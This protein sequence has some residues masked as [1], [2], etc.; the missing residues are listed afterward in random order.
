[1]TSSLILAVQTTSTWSVSAGLV[2]LLCNLFAI[3]VGRFAIQNPGVGPDLP[4]PKPALWKNF[5]VPE[6]I[7][8]A[9]LGHILGAGMILGLSNA[10]AL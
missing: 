5:G 8:T 7:A 4:L 9:S 1:M 3:A 10:G 2:M 6:L